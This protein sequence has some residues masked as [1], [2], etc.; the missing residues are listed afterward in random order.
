MK[1]ILNLPSKSGVYIIENIKTKQC[2]IGSSINIKK[3]CN[4]HRCLLNN[5]KHPNS[6][7]QR[8]YKKYGSQHFCFRIIELTSHENIIDSERLWINKMN[9]EFN[10]REV[11]ESNKGIKL[12]DETRKRMSISRKGKPL[13]DAQIQNINQLNQNR[14]GKQVTGKTKECLRLGPISLIGKS[15]SEST[16]LKISQSKIGRKL[17]PLT[18]KYE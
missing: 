1:S 9:P 3:R 10:L 13:S 17:N 2:Y 11:V 6:K 16:R 7:M 8:S 4:A 15:P 18:R 12:S 5:E 14:I